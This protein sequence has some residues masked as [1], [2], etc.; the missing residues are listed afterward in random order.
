DSTVTP[1][2]DLAAKYPDVCMPMMGLHPCYVNE[3]YEQTLESIAHIFD[4]EKIWAVGEV[5]LDYHWD[6]TYVAEQKKAFDL[7][8][9]W[10]K[11]RELPLVIHSRKSL[12]DSISMVQSRQDG[13]LSGVFHCFDGTIEQAQKIIDLGFYIGIGGV[14]TFKKSQLPELISGIGIDRVVLETDAPYLA[15]V[16]FRGK[17]NESSY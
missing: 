15:P 2:L 13:N 6:L 14:L 10:A 1:L 16:P 9:V 11:E 3:N 17:R 7:Q 5:G 12:D 4:E 8:I